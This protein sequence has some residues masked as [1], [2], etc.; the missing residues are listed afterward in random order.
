VAALTQGA[1]AEI[2]LL[3]RTS[4]PGDASDRSGLKDKLEDGT[5]HNRLGSFGSAIAYTGRGNRYVLVADR[6]PTDGAVSYHCRLQFF[7]ISAAPGRLEATL[8]ETVLLRDSAGEPF[9][10]RAADLGK[11]RDGV[12][13]RLDPEGIRVGKDGTLFLSDE[14]GPYVHQ[15]D[16]R[17]RFRRSL[18]VPP[19]FQ[20]DRPSADASAELSQNKRGRLPNRGMEGLAISPDGSKL[21]GIMQSPL[22]Q[23]GGRA[24]TNVRILEINMASG[25]T[26]EFLYPLAG[27]DN[28]I[29]EILAINARQFLVLE[30]DGKAK[31]SRIMKFDLDGASDISAVERL[32]LKGEPAGIVAVR[33]SVFL[34]LLAPRFGLAGPDFPNKPEGLA[35]GPDLPDGRHLLLVTS[36]NDFIS[37]APSHLFA[38]AIDPADL[39]GLQ[40][41]RFGR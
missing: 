24:G 11:T 39:P 38:F 4:I 26:R 34:D 31:F 37:T 17:G 35:F 16:A 25:A 36:D 13:R 20:I 9:T 21:Y 14:Y 22:L 27:P 32:P 30:R 5:P 2:K 1:A 15:F 33:P 6:G 40:H 19:H 3:A 18:K 7:D 23:D 28:G 10:G 12:A 29:S 8:V 41:Q